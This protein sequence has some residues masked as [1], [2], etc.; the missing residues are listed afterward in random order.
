MATESQSYRVTEL[1]SNRVTEL[2]TPKCTQ[3]TGGWKFFVPD[4]NKL[5]YSLRSQGN[6]LSNNFWLKILLIYQFINWATCV[7]KAMGLNSWPTTTPTP[8]N[9]PLTQTHTTTTLLP[10]CPPNTPDQSWPKPNHKT[11]STRMPSCPVGSQMF[12]FYII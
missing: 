1:Q 7:C 8:R 4:F 9:Y 11:P 2:Q 12:Y 10:A 6:N 5:P 3:Y